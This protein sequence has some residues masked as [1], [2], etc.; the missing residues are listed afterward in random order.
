MG[1]WFWAGE[2]VGVAVSVIE[3][4]VT[5]AVADIGV[6]EAPPVAETSGVSVGTGVEVKAAPPESPSTMGK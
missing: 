2:A 3:E 6:C 5:V 1:L 4:A